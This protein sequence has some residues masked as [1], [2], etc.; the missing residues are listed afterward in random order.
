[1]VPTRC[2]VLLQETRGDVVPSS[3]VLGAGEFSILP[4]GQSGFVFAS[5][6]AEGLA[7]FPSRDFALLP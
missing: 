4:L 2:S 5:S 6:E 3:P 7:C 1:M